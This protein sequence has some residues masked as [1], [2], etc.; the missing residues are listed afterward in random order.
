MIKKCGC[1][2]AHQD[3]LHG[4]GKRVHNAL[5]GRG[6]ESGHRCTVC[7]DVKTATFVAKSDKSVKVVRKSKK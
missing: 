4:K 7:K 6:R 1:V 5:S 2:H 3:K